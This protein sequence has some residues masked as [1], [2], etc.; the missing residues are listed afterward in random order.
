MNLRRLRA[1]G[2]R[3]ADL[4]R[5]AGGHLGCGHRAWVTQIDYPAQVD[6]RQTQ[7]LHSCLGAQA[8]SAGR[9]GEKRASL[10]ECAMCNCLVAPPGEGFRSNCG[11]VSSQGRGPQNTD[12]SKVIFKDALCAHTAMESGP[13]CT[14]FAYLSLLFTILYICLVLSGRCSGKITGT[15]IICLVIMTRFS[16]R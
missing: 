12:A 13:C 8:H 2:A 5:F 16:F 11:Y 6:G 14:C 3:I 1:D 9:I 15:H 4:N 10:H 7:L